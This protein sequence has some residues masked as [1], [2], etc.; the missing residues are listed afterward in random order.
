MVGTTVYYFFHFYIGA[1][2]PVRNRIGSEGSVKYCEGSRHALGREP[3]HSEFRG[4]GA[5]TIPL[6]IPYHYFCILRGSRYLLVSLN[7]IGM[8]GAECTFKD[9][10][11][12]TEKT[13][14]I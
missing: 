6:G 10:L 1:Y 9:P 4:L 8:L 5:V 11:V 14:K 2:S 7:T 13:V 12:Y 3:S